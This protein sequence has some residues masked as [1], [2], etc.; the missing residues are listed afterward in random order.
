MIEKSGLY[1]R[2]RAFLRCDI[3]GK[4]YIDF[5]KPCVVITHWG[6]IICL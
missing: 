2:G 5:T 3:D 4:I 6:G 1:D